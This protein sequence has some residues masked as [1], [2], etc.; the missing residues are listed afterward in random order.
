[1]FKSLTTPEKKF[2]LNM[3]LV[4]RII[5]SARP[6]AAPFFWSKKQC[7]NFNADIYFHVQKLIPILKK[8]EK[9][10]GEEVLSTAFNGLDKRQLRKMY[11]L[12]YSYKTVGKIYAGLCWYCQ[13][14]VDRQKRLSKKKDSGEAKKIELSIGQDLR[15]AE[16]KRVARKQQNLWS[17]LTE[18]FYNEGIKIING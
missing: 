1:M 17:I 6:K 12:A 4:E 16:L 3:H 7:A 15:P 11:E 14:E 5:L 2:G 8:V 9:T 10:Y 13:D 18:Q